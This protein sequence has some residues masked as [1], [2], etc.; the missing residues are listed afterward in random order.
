MPGRFLLVITLV[1]QW[2]SWKEPNRFVVVVVVPF[3]AKWDY[4][5]VYVRCCREIEIDGAFGNCCCCC[6][7]GL[8]VDDGVVDYDDCRDYDC[9]LLRRRLLRLRLLLVF[10]NATQHS[11]IRKRVE[12]E[13]VHHHHLYG[14]T[15]CSPN[16]PLT[17]GSIREVNPGLTKF[18][19]RL[20]R[21]KDLHPRNVLHPHH[22]PSSLGVSPS[23]RCHSCHDS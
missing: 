7:C 6:Y 4:S 13:T 22:T 12:E 15:S 11:P 18:R 20:R 2:D 23:R 21:T 17:R 14:T 1:R 19:L 8:I 10:S 5:E 3:L 9:L 16:V